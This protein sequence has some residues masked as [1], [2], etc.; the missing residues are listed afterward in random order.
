MTLA[1]SSQDILKAPCLQSASRGINTEKNT[2][3]L[4]TKHQKAT[5]IKEMGV[6][7]MAQKPD[8]KASETYFKPRDRFYEFLEQ[9][10]ALSHKRRKAERRGAVYMTLFFCVIITVAFAAHEEASFRLVDK[11]FR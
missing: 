9:H 3:C 2:P 8:R 6:V 11:L 4:L 7:F 10:D 5:I 1:I